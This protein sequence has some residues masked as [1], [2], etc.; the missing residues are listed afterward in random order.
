MTE[1]TARTD[2]AFGDFLARLDALDAAHDALNE[3]ETAEDFFGH[4]G[5]RLLA[6]YLGEDG[7]RIA[8]RGPPVRL[9]RDEAKMLGLCIH[10]L[11]TNA[12]KYGALSTPQGRVSMGL[13]APGA[14]GVARFTWQESGGPP[15]TPPQRTGYGQRF[16]GSTLGALF[17][18]PVDLAYRPEGFHL[19]VAGPAPGLFAASSPIAGP[20]V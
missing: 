7:A 1:R 5:R 2:E 8:V 16:L 6:P 12:A 17:A 19:S 20:Q 15:V 9:A 4:L 10:E 14:D 13:S 18:G 3:S 11:A